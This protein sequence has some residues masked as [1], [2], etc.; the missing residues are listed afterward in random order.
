VAPPRRYDQE[1]NL[2]DNTRAEA[3]VLD[4]LRHLVRGD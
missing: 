2:L 1:G 4:R 3:G